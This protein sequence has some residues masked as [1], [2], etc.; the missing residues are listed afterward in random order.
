MHFCV[1]RKFANCGRREGEVLSGGVACLWLRWLE[2][3]SSCPNLTAQ[4]WL[5]LRVWDS[6]SSPFT[7]IMHKWTCKCV[8]QSKMSILNKSDIWTDLVRVST[9][10]AVEGA[11]S[12]F[13]VACVCTAVYVFMSGVGVNHRTFVADDV[14]PFLIQSSKWPVYNIFIIKILDAYLACP[15]N[16]CI[17]FHLNSITTVW[18][19]TELQTHLSFVISFICT[20]LPLLLG[21]ASFS[22]LCFFEYFLL[23]TKT[24]EHVSQPF[25]TNFYTY[26]FA[27]CKW[28]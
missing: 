6:M 12:V 15:I 9:R 13:K 10:L 16:L 14:I 5:A 25:E 22:E 18:V 19:H 24:R 11:W 7:V 8:H 23:S 4:I 21:Q 3:G 26:F 27:K 28:L 17:P 1:D 2:A 20:L